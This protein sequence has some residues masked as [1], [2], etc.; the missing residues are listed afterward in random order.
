MRISSDSD[1]SDLA[2]SKGEQRQDRRY[3]TDD[4]AQ[5][6]VLPDGEQRLAARILNVSRSGVQ[7]QLDTALEKGTQVEVVITGRASI[8]GEIRY[9][10]KVGERF[11]AGVVIYDAVF[12]STQASEHIDHDRLS[13]Y[14]AGQGLTA[15]ELL[16]IKD[17]LTK[18]VECRSALANTTE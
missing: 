1:D 6:T 15:S 2:S 5:V 17:H 3:A 14:V 18:C 9:C 13:L 11:R 16:S 4:N 10:L 7:V 12:P 8:V